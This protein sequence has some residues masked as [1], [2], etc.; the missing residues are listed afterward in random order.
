MNVRG[1]DGGLDQRI[2]RDDEDLLLAAIGRQAADGD[3]YELQDSR[4][5]LPAAVPDYPGP[6][7]ILVKGR[8]H[9]VQRMQL[10]LG[11]RDL[12]RVDK[13]SDVIAHGIIPT[14][15]MM[16]RACIAIRRRAQQSGGSMT[17][18]PPCG[19]PGNPLVAILDYRDPIN[20]AKGSLL[21]CGALCLSGGITKTSSDRCCIRTTP[22]AYS[23]GE[24]P[25]A[26][27]LR[28][29]SP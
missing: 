12:L 7:V 28:D 9:L 18:S 25:L 3:P 27:R 24:R 16:A 8:D 2:G 10:L 13:T 17:C 4:R 6:L 5:I 26:I 15:A 14:L 29:A 20:N 23:T 19:P 22:N 21:P 11:Q 1:D